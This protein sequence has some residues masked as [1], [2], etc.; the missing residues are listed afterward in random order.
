MKVLVNVTVSK[1]KRLG[2]P[3]TRVLTQWSILMSISYESIR[4]TFWFKTNNKDTAEMTVCIPL[5][6]HVTYCLE[7]VCF[8]SRKDVT[9]IELLWPMFSRLLIQMYLIL[10]SNVTN[11]QLF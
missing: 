1:K 9:T 2:P 6:S 3:R 11:A 4:N 10:L 5:F 7:D 8:A